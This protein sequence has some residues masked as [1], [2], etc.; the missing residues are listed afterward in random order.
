MIVRPHLSWLRM[1]FVW[2]GSIVPKIFPRL[3]FVVLLAF[4][5]TALRARFPS[6]AIRLEPGPLGLLGVTLAIFLGFRNST[7][8]ERFWEARKLWGSLLNTSR[9]LSR[10]AFTMPSPALSRAERLHVAHL[11]GALARTLVA[12]LRG[13]R[14]SADPV[15][16]GA[17]AA[18]VERGAYKPARVM[19]ELGRFLA[20]LRRSDRIDAISFAAIDQNLDRLSDVIGGCERIAGTPIPLVYSVL[21]HRTVYAYSIVLPIA[22]VDRLGFWTPWV[23]LLVSYTFIGLDAVTAELED[24]FGTEANDLPLDAMTR[25]IERATLDLADAPL[26]PSL[27][28]DARFVLR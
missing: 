10:Q 19:L 6:F 11:L 26:P 12:Q 25:T 24:P 16:D 5:V 28:P 21:L 15:L 13:E 3:A 1:L 2:R 18:R 20:E 9:S 14:A 17:V 7:S 8:Y 22:L 27:E 23:T 4:V